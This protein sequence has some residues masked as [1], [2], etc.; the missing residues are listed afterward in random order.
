MEDMTDLDLD[1]TTHNIW[2]SAS[3]SWSISGPL[4]THKHNLDAT[5][6]LFRASKRNCIKKKAALLESVAAEVPGE[7]RTTAKSSWESENLGMNGWRS[8]FKK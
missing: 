8:S 2:L 5:R 7:V 4:L 6:E 3:T 1:G